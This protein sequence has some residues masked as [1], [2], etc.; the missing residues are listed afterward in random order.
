M[1]M[2]KILQSFDNVTSTSKADGN[3]IKKFLQIVEGANTISQPSVPTMQVTSNVLNV[4]EDATPGM[5][6][7]YFK[8]VEQEFVESAER[9]AERSKDRAR[10]LAERVIERIVPG[11]EPSAVPAAP[12]N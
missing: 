11:Q 4:K 10:L 8:T 12:T 1:D 5:F 3:S 9:S 7:K 2:K 6:G